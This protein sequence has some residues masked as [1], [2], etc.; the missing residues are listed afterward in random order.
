[1]E[2]KKFTEKESLELISHMIQATRKNLVKDQG[3]YFIIYGYTAAILSVI[4]YTLLCMTPTPWWWA[5]WFLMFLPVIVLAFKGKG[6]PR[7]SSLT[8]TAWSTKSGKW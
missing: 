4:I 8:R 3:N 2:E 7:P 1:M 5:G 6:T